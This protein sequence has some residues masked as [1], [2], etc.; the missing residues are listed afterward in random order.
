MTLPP[1]EN[2][3][4]LVEP[5]FPYRLTVFCS[6]VE[7]VFHLVTGKPIIGAISL[8]QSNSNSPFAQKEGRLILQFSELF[9]GVTPDGTLL[10]YH[11][12][13]TQWQIIKDAPSN[14]CCLLTHRMKRHLSL[15]SILKQILPF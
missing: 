15:D 3:F 4:D 6:Q 2:S 7:M 10:P 1:S 5:P 13:V 12:V 9:F 8:E 14:D 11:I